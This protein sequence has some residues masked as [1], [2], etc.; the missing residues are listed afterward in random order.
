[1]EGNR[2]N[3]NHEA[4]G[5]EIAEAVEQAVAEAQE[6]ATG[7]RLGN[8]SFSAIDDKRLGVLPSMM[9]AIEDINKYRQELKTAD[10]K[11][12]WEASKAVAAIHERLMCGVDITPI[13]DRIVAESAG[14]NSAKLE[15]VIRGLTH[16]VFNTNS[17]PMQPKHFWNKGGKG[18]EAPSNT[19]LMG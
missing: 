17:N 1:M 15:M 14:V 12:R 5:I 6:K 11:D 18:Q 8:S 9:Q 4:A 13:I 10:W 2:G 3:G 16:T 7:K 19:E